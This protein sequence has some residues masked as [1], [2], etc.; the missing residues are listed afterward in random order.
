VSAIASVLTHFSGL[1]Y[2]S[3][4]SVTELCAD[5]AVAWCPSVCPSVRLSHACIVSKR[6]N[7]SSNFFSILTF[8]RGL[9]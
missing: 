4:I 8:R 6:I 3:V 1:F 7:I 9:P 2:F 5:Y